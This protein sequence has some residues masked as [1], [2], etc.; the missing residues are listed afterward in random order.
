MMK[1]R[2]VYCHA[3]DELGYI[4][5]YTWIYYYIQYLYCKLSATGGLALG[6]FVN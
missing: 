3:A 4:Y 2:V 1:H 5:V 6:I